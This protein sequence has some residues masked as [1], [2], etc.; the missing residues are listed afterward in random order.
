[1]AGTWRTITFSLPAEMAQRLDDATKS[2][3]C[4]RSE[5][6]RAAVQRFIVE[7]PDWQRLLRYGESRTAEIGI[8]SDDV[9]EL[10]EEYRADRDPARA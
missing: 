2:E 6:L 3:G 9:A 7:E 1:M 10:V 4:T 5:L 8:R